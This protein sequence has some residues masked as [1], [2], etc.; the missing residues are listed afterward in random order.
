MRRLSI[1]KQ[2]IGY[3]TIILRK[4]GKIDYVVIDDSSGGYTILT[5]IPPRPTIIE[6]AINRYNDLIDLTN[7]KFNLITSQHIQNSATIVSVS[8][9]EDVNTILKL[10]NENLKRRLKNT[11]SDS[12][13]KNLRE[14]LLSGV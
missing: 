9:Q 6:D 7:G 4:D 14:I 3:Y 1:M 11:F 12:E 10:Y 5:N 2:V 8:I 13:I